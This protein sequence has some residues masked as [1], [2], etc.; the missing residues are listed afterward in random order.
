M[1]TYKS[2]KQLK[3]EGFETPFEAKL[4]ANNRWVKLSQSIP[5][6][7]LASGYYRNLSST[8]GRPAKDAR[9]VIGAVI[10]KHKLCLSDEAAV[11]QIQ[12]NFYLQYFVG[13][14]VTIFLSLT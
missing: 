14:P 9:L 5:W 11:L 13:F 12:E 1:I 2:Q 7:E 6:D 3:L 8:Q 4:D 10:I